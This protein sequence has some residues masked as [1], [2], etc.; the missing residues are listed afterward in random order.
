MHICTLHPSQYYGSLGALN[1]AKY[2]FLLK[3]G[4]Q[5]VSD[6]RFQILQDLASTY[7]LRWPCSSSLDFGISQDLGW[8]DLVMSEEHNLS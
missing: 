3:M 5:G 1:S 8:L 7:V 6:F 4:F 2:L